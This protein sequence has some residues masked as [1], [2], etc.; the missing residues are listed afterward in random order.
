MS[1][2]ALTFD[3]DESIANAYLTL[4][5]QQ[6][7]KVKLLLLKGLQEELD[8]SAQKEKVSAKNGSSLMGLRG[9]LSDELSDEEV[10]IMHFKEKYGL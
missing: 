9:I 6:S 4:L 1:T 8:N 2:S 10:R 5:R 7:K 3:L